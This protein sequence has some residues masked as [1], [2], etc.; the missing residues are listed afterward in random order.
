MVPAIAGYHHFFVT[1]DA[2]VYT[3]CAHAQ[4]TPKV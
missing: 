4:L 3:L 2:I 1:D